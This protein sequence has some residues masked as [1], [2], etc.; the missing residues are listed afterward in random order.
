M[1]ARVSANGWE[2]LF[3]SAFDRSANPM[4]LLQSDRVLV[5]VNHSF[6]EDLGYQ[7]E[8][9]IGTRSDRVDGAT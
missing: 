6:V 1:T 3:W 2:T 7:P 4:A 9:T 8:E 5:A